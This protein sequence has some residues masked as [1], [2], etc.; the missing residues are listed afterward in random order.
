MKTLNN[1]LLTYKLSLLVGCIFIVTIYPYE[2]VYAFTKLKNGFETV[3]TTYLLPLSKA[4][5]G[6][7]LIF[8]LLMSYFNYQEYQKKAAAV[9]G[10]AIFSAVGVETL[11]SIIQSFS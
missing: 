4:I 11:N 10:I 5:A 7:S 8:Y 2:S 3:T 6:A 9:V 1:K